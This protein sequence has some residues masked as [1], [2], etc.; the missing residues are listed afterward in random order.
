MEKIRKMLEKELNDV[1]SRFIC[2]Y[3]SD[4]IIEADNSNYEILSL[5]ETAEKKSSEAYKLFK[6]KVKSPG[7]MVKDSIREMMNS[8][9]EEY[10]KDH[11]NA[12][13]VAAITSEYTKTNFEPLRN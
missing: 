10:I 3:I 1:T 8:K 13:A 5:A 2:K 4:S 9:A 7:L 11:Y 6:E 12:E